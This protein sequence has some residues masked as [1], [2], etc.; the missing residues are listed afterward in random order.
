MPPGAAAAAFG[1]NNAGSCTAKTMELVLFGKAFMSIGFVPLAAALLPSL[2]LAAYI[3]KADRVEKEP[4]GLLFRLFFL[5]ALSGI[6]AGFLEGIG[7]LAL[8]AF[9]PRGSAGYVFAFAFLVVAMIEEGVKFFVLKKMTW[10]HRAFNHQF[11]AIVYS[12]FVSLGFAALENVG[13][14]YSFG[15]SVLLPRALLAVPAHMGLSVYMGIYYGRAKYYDNRGDRPRCRLNLWKAYL[16]A[17][18]LHGFYDYCLMRQSALSGWIFFF[19]VAVM[20]RS[21]RRR[22]KSE[23]AGDMA[24]PQR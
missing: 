5:G 6:A 13:Y 12:V 10:R 24:L 19:F 22:I 4:P 16:W 8:A 23:S 3:F 1:C 11:D 20:Y 2:L 9:Y 7:E 14:L 15:A 21:V 17:V 18:V